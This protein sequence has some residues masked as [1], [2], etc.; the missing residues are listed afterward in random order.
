MLCSRRA[1]VALLMLA[2]CKLV[3]AI[4]PLG[5]TGVGVTATLGPGVNKGE[6]FRGVV[7]KKRGRL[8]CSTK[9]EELEVSLDQKRKIKAKRKSERKKRE[10]RNEKRQKKEK[11]EKIVQERLSAKACPVTTSPLCNAGRA[12]LSGVPLCTASKLKEEDSA[13]A[14]RSRDAMYAWARAQPQKSGVVQIPK[15]LEW[16]RWPGKSCARPEHSFNQHVPESKPC[17]DAY[18]TFSMAFDGSPGS[19]WPWK[20]GIPVFAVEGGTQEEMAVCRDTLAA[21][22]APRP[23][24]GYFKSPT[25][26]INALFEFRTI[27]NCGNYGGF[28]MLPW[29]DTSCERFDRDKCVGW[30][31]GGPANAY[32]PYA[33]AERTGLCTVG[34]GSVFKGFETKPLGHTVAMEEYG[35][36][37]FSLAISAV[38]PEGWIAAGRAMHLAHQRGSFTL[39]KDEGEGCF[40]NALEYIT[41]CIEHVMWGTRFNAEGF[42][43]RDLASLIETD[44]WGYCL[45]IRWFPKNNQWTPCKKA[46]PNVVPT[47]NV[48]P[49]TPGMEVVD[50]EARLREIGVT[51][52]TRDAHGAAV[53]WGFEKAKPESIYR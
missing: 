22:V 18:T 2:V 6:G 14:K 3:Q 39:G 24:G 32:F 36:S 40:G 42:K 28:P 21:L 41:S 47:P 4:R 5:G 50:C 48:D 23:V 43:P 10:K 12:S 44:P 46:F 17:T 7:E 33:F 37:V 38:D 20:R 35:H 30:K 9:R 51:T 45:A 1:L 29:S 8:K 19:A 11:K 34:K 13:E 16:N 26:L 25:E 53:S 49:V 31:S 15:G 52:F 27:F